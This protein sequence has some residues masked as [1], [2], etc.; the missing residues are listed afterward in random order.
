M[1]K[2]LRVGVIGL[3]PLWHKR[4][5]PPL[6]ALRAHLQVAAVCDQ[7]EHHAAVE[8]R[9]VGCAAAAG[10]TDLLE[11]EDVEAVLLLDPQW[12]R[13]WPVEVACRLGKPVFCCPPLDSDDAHADALCEQVRTSRLPLVVEMIPRAAPAV[14]RLREL[15]ETRLGSC[16][17]LLAEVVEGPLGSTTGPGPGGE[18]ALL[19]CC[20]GLISGEPTA[21]SAVGLD[22]A[23]LASFFLEFDGGRAIQVTRYRAPRPRGGMRLHAVAERGSAT[24]EFPNRLHWDDADGHHTHVAPMDRPL[25]QVLLEQFLE[26]VR[27]GRAPEPGLDEVCRLLGWVRAAARSLAQGHRIELGNATSESAC[28]EQASLS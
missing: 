24:L 13:L 23:D 26:V 1:T 5:K 15:L 14:R 11:K 8:A 18:T 4:Y 7:V 17:L 9:R 19:D 28:L 25:G 20:R 12:Y 6:L 2:P 10:P 27:A 22:R 3:G 16:R 21:C